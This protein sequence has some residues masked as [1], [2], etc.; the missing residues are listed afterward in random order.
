MPRE[1]QARRRARV[2][3]IRE[4]LRLTYPDARCELNYTSPLELLVATILSA[5]CSDKQVNRLTADLFRKYRSAHDYAAASLAELEED[6]RRIGL[7]R[8][9]ARSLQGCCRRLVEEHGGQVPD[10]LDILMQLDGVGRKT[11]NVVLGNAFGRNDGVVVDT[12]VT[13]LSC[14]LALS[15]ATQPERI[16][17]D[18]MALLPQEEWTLWSH[19]LI[20]HGRRRCPARKP[21]CAGCEL[22]TWCPT[23]QAHN[24]R[25]RPLTLA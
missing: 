8:N 13:R 10:A 14:R 6:L 12:H 3:L 2:D 4:R 9:K 24:N 23:G 1:S 16:E 21:D 5:Q 11:A 18:L 22:R 19:L 15:S 20:A 25:D 7:F 17:H